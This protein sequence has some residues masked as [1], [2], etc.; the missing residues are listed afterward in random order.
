MPLVENYTK[1]S[2]KASGTEGSICQDSVT[3]GPRGASGVSAQSPGC[4]PGLCEAREGSKSDC[5]G[6]CQ[7]VLYAEQVIIQIF[8]RSL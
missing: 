2:G 5:E 1:R 4:R 3:G 6:P 7:P 8:G